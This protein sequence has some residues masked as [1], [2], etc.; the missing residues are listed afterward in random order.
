MTQQTRKRRPYAARMPIEER[1]TQLLDAALRVIDRD[2]YDGVSID[3]IAKEAGVTRPVVYGAFDG[4]GPLLTALLDRQ[5]QR[6]ITQ[7][8]AALPTETATDAVAVVDL[9]GPRLHQMLLDDPVTW[10]AILQ[11]PANVPEVVRARIEA[12]RQQVRTIIEGLV[13]GVLGPKVDA[14]VMAHGIIALLEHFG[15]L[16]LDDPE[17][18]DAARLTAAA[19]ALAASWTP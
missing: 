11:S 2:G 13:T 7:L 1:R 18:Y 19:R 4:L 8:F 9:S 3:A 17:E 14:P 12:D 10:R 15:R 6:A 5:Q 16:V